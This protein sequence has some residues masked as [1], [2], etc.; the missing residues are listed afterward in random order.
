MADR[1]TITPSELTAAATAFDTGLDQL[2]QVLADLDKQVNSLV[3]SWAGAAETAFID[4][5]TSV[6]K[7][8]KEEMGNVCT[9]VAQQL[10][11]VAKT[12]EDT[13]QDLASQLNA[14]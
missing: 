8:V 12:L 3:S 13:D 7:K 4:N 1:I 11:G 9:T 10:R 6:S 14:R 2:N 5:Y